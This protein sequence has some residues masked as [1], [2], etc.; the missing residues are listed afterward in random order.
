MAGY[1]HPEKRF[2]VVFEFLSLISTIKN[3][4]AKLLPDSCDVN[5]DVTV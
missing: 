1:L 3:V 5:M 4:A 2:L